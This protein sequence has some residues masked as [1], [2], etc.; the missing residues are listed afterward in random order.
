M[1]SVRLVVL[2][3]LL[4]AVIAGYGPAIRTGQCA[5]GLA[6]HLASNLAGTWGLELNDSEPSGEPRADFLR[7][8]NG[9][10]YARTDPTSQHHR[11]AYWRDLRLSS[12]IWLF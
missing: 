12:P 1:R 2:L 9:G 10:S 7:S 8:A 4:L 3:S 11:A 6:D 5:F